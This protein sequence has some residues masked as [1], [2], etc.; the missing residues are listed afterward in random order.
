[1]PQPKPTDAEIE[2][3]AHRHGLGNLAPEHIARMA[4][5]AVYV[6]EL[7]RTLARPSRKEDAPA[8]TFIPSQQH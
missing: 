3:F 1:M 6:G 5:L 4:E 7:G 2:A 8:A